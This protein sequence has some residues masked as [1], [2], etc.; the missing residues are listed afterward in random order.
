M[1]DRT[2]EKELVRKIIQK[3]EQA[4][5]EFVRR[6]EKDVFHFINKQLR[7]KELSEEVTQDVFID[8]LDALRDFQF[9]SSLKTFLFSIAKYKTIDV[10]RKKKVKKVLFSGLPDYVVE[11]L[12]AVVMD[13][14]LEKKELVQKMDRVLNSLPFKYRL[15]LQLKYVE[16]VRVKAIADRLSMNFKSTESLLFRARKAFIELFQTTQ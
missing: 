1:K 7:N 12:G 9:Q 8:F 11:R 13:D 14:E 15:I 4:F 16:G 6:Y 10:I 3:D 2:A 5:F